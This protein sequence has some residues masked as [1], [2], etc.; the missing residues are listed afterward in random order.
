M[1]GL[2][3]TINKCTAAVGRRAAL[4]LALLCYIAVSQ[5]AVAHAQ[6]A[7]AV[8]RVSTASELK[9]AI[10]GGAV[11]ILIVEH[12]DLTTLPNLPNSQPYPKLFNPGAELRSITVR[13]SCSNSSDN[14]VAIAHANRWAAAR[15]SSKTA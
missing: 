5:V 3:A 15:V 13:R 6:K 2:S 4:H 9:K 10:E 12:L 11:D 14:S 1:A 7:G 8:T